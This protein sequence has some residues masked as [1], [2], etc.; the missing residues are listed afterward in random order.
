MHQ[1]TFLHDWAKTRDGKPGISVR[2]HLLA[3]TCVAEELLRHFPRFCTIHG[4]PGSIVHFLAAVHDVGK[5]SLDFLQ[6][7]PAWLREQGL[8]EQAH[9]K[10]WPGIYHRW[11]PLISQESLQ[12]F[13]QNLQLPVESAFM[14]G[15]VVGIH[16]GRLVKAYTS[17]PFRSD[18]HSK[19]LE[20]E[21]QQC[22]REMWERCGSPALPAVKKEDT[23]LWSI[24]GL[25]T[26]A[27][28]I[29]SDEQFFP[30][31]IELSEDELRRRAEAAVLSTGLGLPPMCTGLSFAEIFSG[32][33]PYPLQQ[34]VAETITGPGIYIIEAPMGMGKTEAALFAASHLLRQGQASGLFFALPTQATSNRMFLRLAQF[35]RIICPKAAPTQLIHGNSWLLD[36]LKELAV[37]AS[38]DAGDKGS[39]L[40]TDSLWFNTTRRA[41]F[42]PF[43]VGT[44]D[45][46]LL[47]VLAVKHFPLRRF[48]LT[49]KIVILD[50]VHT[51]DVYTG[52]LIQHLCNELEKL[53]CTVIVLSATLTDTMR[54]NLLGLSGENEDAGVPNTRITGRVQDK[55]IKL[56]CPPSRPDVQVC[57][58][59]ASE[60]EA[61]QQALDLAK[62]GAQV[63]WVCDTVAHAQNAFRSL[64]E[65]ADTPLPLG[66]LHSR[67]P[68]FMRTRLE[69][70]WLTRFG[71]QGTRQGGAI[72][73]STQVVEQSVDL[74]A[75][76]LFSE[77]APTDML[78]QRLGRLWR[79]ERAGRP[80]PAPLL[81]LLRESANLEELCSMTANDIKKT[82]GDKAFV[83]K[84][85]VL[86]RSLEQWEPL[87]S[88][89]LP[90]DI[91]PLMAATYAD[92]E[93]PPGWEDLA[94]EVRGT[95]AAAKQLADMGANIWQ[96]ALEDDAGL[97]TRLSDNEDYTFVLCR[98]DTG[99]SICLLEESIL[100]VLDKKGISLQAAK[101]LHR[102][103]IKISSRHFAVPPNDTRLD[104]CFIDGCILVHEDGR[105]E[106]AGLK[107]GRG[108]AW[109][110]QLG[111]ILNKEGV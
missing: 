18:L 65:Q 34:M 64:R 98:A 17:R 53:G 42:A 28:W 48:A 15:A 11:H 111:I 74:D 93:C 50:E 76:V 81:C 73:V 97:C 21:R 2:Q 107:P 20:D 26:L 36:D 32:N 69:E 43:G 5:I 66:L 12:L 88:L 90:S 13:L 6:K 57:I 89:A 71:P 58:V 104:S 62:Q 99:K 92:K 102:N 30:A 7:S 61:R 46:A 1:K 105:A 24:A 83:Y 49:G 23:R 84:P 51:Y 86:L 103:T 79:H 91:R 85:Y 37:P 109:D 14:W 55:K 54:C 44:I 101:H 87:G 78:L 33:K 82:L 27:D 70:I 45:Q 4:I 110:E 96:V 39:P 10:N 80:L 40:S 63:L 31:D 95:A 25:I 75:D 22:L 56:V 77:L 41:L 108:L 38:P 106:V 68:F 19:P 67:F 72:L 59:H 94:D 100:V 60:A 29:G 8:E 16:H 3:V 35:A 9:D 52:R 47:S